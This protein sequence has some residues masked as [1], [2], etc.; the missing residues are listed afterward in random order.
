MNLYIDLNCV[1]LILAL[2]G[3]IAL[4]LLIITLFRVS[5]LIKNI[6]IIVSSN[7]D[8]IQ[9]VCN[10][11]PEISGNIKEATENAK[12]VT[13]VVTEVTADAIVAKE[14]FQSNFETIK[15]ILNIVLSV[16]SKK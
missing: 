5:T 9:K 16:F 3:I 14:S 13:E 4:V 11:A 8:N 6:N 1:Y 10:D 2:V 12:S 15:D 7:K